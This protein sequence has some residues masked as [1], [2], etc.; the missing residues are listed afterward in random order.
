MQVNNGFACG[1]LGEDIPQTICR[2]QIPGALDRGPDP[3]GVINDVKLIGLNY[4][5]LRMV[6]QTGVGRARAIEENY[7]VTLICQP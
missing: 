4:L 5:D 6:L 7:L 3:V 1:C 2:F